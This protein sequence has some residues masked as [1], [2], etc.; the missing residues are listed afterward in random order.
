MRSNRLFQNFSKRLVTEALRR[1]IAPSIVSLAWKE[2]KTQVKE[3]L[4]TGGEFPEDMLE[5]AS[6][7]FREIWEKA[8]R[9]AGKKTLPTLNWRSATS[10]EAKTG[11]R[12]KKRK[13]KVTKA[14]TPFISYFLTIF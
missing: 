3:K 13:K 6:N 7:G 9:R 2:G 12:K 8:C 10:Q 5:S 1:G 14:L 11:K 4:D